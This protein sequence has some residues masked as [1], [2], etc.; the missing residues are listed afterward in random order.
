MT[1]TPGRSDKPVI[2][3]DAD[4]LIAL[5]HEDDV[6]HAAAVRILQQL[7]EREAHILFPLTAVTEAITT[8]QRKLSN[9]NL[10]DQLVQQVKAGAVAIEV[11]DK[12]VFHQALTLFA[13]HASKQNT[14][15][16]AIVATVARKYRADAIFSFDRWYPKVGLVLTAD[17]VA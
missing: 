12:T 3:G 2:I 13:P 17:M 1:T 15:L 16:D 10:A 4:G 11:V 8:I 14:L 9:P 7:I 5:A 6:H